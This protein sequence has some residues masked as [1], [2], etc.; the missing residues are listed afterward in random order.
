MTNVAQYD[1]SLFYEKTNISAEIEPHLIELSY[2]D[3]L[4]GQSDELSV[5]FEDIQGKW[6]RQWFP[7]QG[8][9]LIAAI[10]YKGSPLVEIGGFEIDEVEYAARPSTITLRAL[11]SGISK[12]YRTLKPKAYENTTLAQI[13]AQVAG[14]L[15]L[16]VVG[17]I[18]PIPIKRVTQYQERDVEFLSRLAR[19]YH[20]SFKIVGEQLV[21]THK[22]E[23][24]QSNPVAVLDEQ[25]VISLRLR[26]RIKDTAKAVEIKG[27]DANGK[28]V[29][30]QRKNASKR[31][32]SIQQ[33]AEASGDTLRI[34]TRGETQEQ[35]DARTDAALAEQN[36]DQQAGNITLWGN[37]KLVAGNTILLRNLGV[38]SGKYLIK[39]T[40][41]S[42]NR[43]SGYQTEIEVRML[44]FIPDDLITLGMEATYANP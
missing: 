32:Q 12:N 21:F 20:H 9:K 10:G 18:K 19:E 29:I 5:T 28:Q 2:T 4:E 42:L 36:D 25:D 16:K 40:R 44:E 15:K 31:R 38:F 43:F 14:H 7:T 39:S 1:F 11:S 41:H 13:V 22:D 30:K 35:I 26:D 23:L 37:P 8:D 33:S 34:V 27:F 3:Y 24:G 17:T 6:I